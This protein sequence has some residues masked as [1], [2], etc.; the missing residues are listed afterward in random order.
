V[1][2]RGVIGAF[3]GI[4]LA[5]A[6]SLG[7]AEDAGSINL[8]LDVDKGTLP[9]GE[10]MTITVRAV[11]VGYNTVTLTGPS[12][13]LLYVQVLSNEGQV[14]WTSQGQCSGAT[15]TEDLQPGG[16]KSL[17]IIWDGSSLAGARLTSGFYHIRGIARVTGAP[18]IGPP[19]SVSLE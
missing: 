8:Y 11:N 19:L 15:V 10:S 18:Y 3:S 17:T 16:E 14:V 9:V 1:R 13:C 7:N 2:F 12:D 5:A 6:C 4:V